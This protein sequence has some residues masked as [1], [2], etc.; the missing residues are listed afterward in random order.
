MHLKNYINGVWKDSVTGRTFED[1]DPANGDL[2]AIVTLS[3]AA[4]VNE[5]V[6]A[7]KKAQQQWRLVPAPVKGDILMKASRILE[8]RKE[9]IARELTC[10]M[11]KVIAEAR[12]DVQEAIDMFNLIGGEGRRLR[13]ETVPS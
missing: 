8:E 7:A 9:D 13:C 1:H 2:L 3:S 10:E 5:A 12:G 6:F 4:D 11:G